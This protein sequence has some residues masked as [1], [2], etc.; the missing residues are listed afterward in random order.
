MGW[1]TSDRAKEVIAKSF[2]G[3][4]EKYKNIFTIIDQQ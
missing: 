4:E 2:N 1:D 3:K